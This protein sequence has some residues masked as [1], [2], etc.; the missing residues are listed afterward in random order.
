MEF[1]DLQ[2]SLGELIDV[3]KEKSILDK[4]RKLDN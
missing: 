4:L 3:E 1:A 2:V